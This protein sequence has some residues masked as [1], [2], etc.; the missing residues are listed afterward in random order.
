MRPWILFSLAVIAVPL[1]GA[2]GPRLGETIDVSV[3]NVD[4][5][6]TDHQGN[7]VRGLTKDDF[8]IF[9]NGKLQPISNFS[10]I[11]ITQS[12]GGVSVVHQPRTIVVFI[13][14]FRAPD[15]RRDPFFNGMREFLH[16]T[17]R[18]GGSVKIATSATKTG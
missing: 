16:R 5:I 7:R 11:G 15:F 18:P 13:E 9:E 12:Q 3:V 6:V 10:E 2:D 17:V 14:H 4:A 1:L 8:Q